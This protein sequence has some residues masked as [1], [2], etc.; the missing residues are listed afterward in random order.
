MYRNAEGH[1]NILSWV[2]CALTFAIFYLL[3]KLLTIYTAFCEGGAAPYRIQ[4]STPGITIHGYCYF[5][6]DLFHVQCVGNNA[7][8][9]FL[10]ISLLTCCA[11]LISIFTKYLLMCG[12]RYIHGIVKGHYIS[13]KSYCSYVSIYGFICR[14]SAVCVKEVM[15]T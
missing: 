8:F 10:F 4:G 2:F 12:F 14:V 5:T 9:C 6:I 13:N 3:R 1:K 11:Q 15:Y 7:C